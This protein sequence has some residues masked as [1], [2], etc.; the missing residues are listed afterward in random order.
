MKQPAE[1]IVAKLG[2]LAPAGKRAEAREQQE[3]RIVDRVSQMMDRAAAKGESSTVE[4]KHYRIEQ[5]EDGSRS[6][7]RNQSQE[8]SLKI[9][10]DGKKVDSFLQ[11]DDRERLA[12]K[13]QPQRSQKRDREAVGMEV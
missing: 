1:E 4:G 10:P 13:P 2:N 5:H 3:A 6:L 9:A 12:Q 11:A 7:T 8:P